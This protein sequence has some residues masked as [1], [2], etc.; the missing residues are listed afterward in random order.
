MDG[1]QDAAES[2]QRECQNGTGITRR[3]MLRGLGV[4]AA[5]AAPGAASLLA[6]ASA[7][8]EQLAHAGDAEQRHRRRLR[9]LNNQAA[10]AARSVLVL[11]I[12]QTVSGADRQAG[13][14]CTRSG[15]VAGIRRTR[16]VS[17]PSD[18]NGAALAVAVGGPAL[19]HGDVVRAGI[20]VLE[21]E[22]DTITWVV[23]TSPYVIVP[24]F[25]WHG[26]AV[27]RRRGSRGAG[28]AFPIYA[29]D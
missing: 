29:R 14:R 17:D 22:D 7:A 24:G 27:D 18:P 21:F 5:V 3:N 20:E 12:E 28:S 16:F 1:E 2:G 8:Q 25:F 26:H 15:E 4:T 6:T 13:D 11:V 23:R 10:R 9:N 19:E